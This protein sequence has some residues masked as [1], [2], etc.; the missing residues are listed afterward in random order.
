[1]NLYLFAKITATEWTAEL[2]RR[3]VRQEN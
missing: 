2:V 3:G 1:L